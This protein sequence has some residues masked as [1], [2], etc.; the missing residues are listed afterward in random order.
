MPVFFPVP[1][2]ESLQQLQ[3]AQRTCPRLAAGKKMGCKTGKKMGC[4]T[5]SQKYPE[6]ASRSLPSRNWVPGA[7]S[8][9]KLPAKARAGCH[10]AGSSSLRPRWSKS[11]GRAGKRRPAL[12]PLSHPP[13]WGVPSLL[14]LGFI[15]LIPSVASPNRPAAQIRV[16]GRGETLGKA[17]AGAVCEAT[18]SSH[19]S[20]VLCALP[21][22]Q[23]HLG[24]PRAATLRVLEHTEARSAA[25][26]DSEHLARPQS[27]LSPASSTRRGCPG[28]APRATP[29]MF[30][31][32]S[33][34]PG[35]RGGWTRRALSAPQSSSASSAGF[36]II[37]CLKTSRAAIDKKVP[38]CRSWN[39]MS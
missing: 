29:S 25:L 22:I 4:K 26:R 35:G 2:C 30:P 8:S 39:L 34:L 18:G 10:R 21:N 36:I 32:P 5:C 6:E 15:D 28:L 33:P 12:L 3:G 11:T 16:P 20:Q 7:E 37:I 19:P 24:V 23:T 1:S 31:S 13:C 14:L 9:P 17:V 38:S 27:F